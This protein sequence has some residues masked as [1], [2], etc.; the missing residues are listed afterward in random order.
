M[1][2][3]V[4]YY[5]MARILKNWIVINK[6]NIKKG[7]TDFQLII[8]IILRVLKNEFAWYK[9]STKMIFF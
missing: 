7:L 2:L 4:K 8:L 1:I 3:I 5:L 9:L 6:L